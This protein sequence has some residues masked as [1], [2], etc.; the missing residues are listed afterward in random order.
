ML[1]VNMAEVYSGLGRH[2]DALSYMQKALHLS[3]DSPDLLNG[4]G[5]IHVLRKDPESAKKCYVQALNL[6]PDFPDAY[7][8]LGIVMRGWD[9]I[10]EAVFCFRNALRFN[11]GMVSALLNL[12][13]CLLS[14]L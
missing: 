6:R 1:L 13:E 9:R 12:G 5:N 3:P 11:P 7:H 2:D 10:D 4:M 14:A 8:N